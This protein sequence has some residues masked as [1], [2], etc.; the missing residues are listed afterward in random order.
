MSKK[1]WLNIRNEEEKTK[2]YIN[3]DIESDTWN[4]GFYEAWGINDTSVYPLVVKDALDGAEGEVEIHINSC[5]G[6]VFA[7][8]AISNMI[9]SYKGPTVAYVDGLAASAAS[10]IALACDKVIIPSNAYLMIHRVSGGLWGNADDFAKAIEAFEVL[11]EGIIN[12]Y[13]EKVKD[14]VSRETI[15]DYLKAETWFT[16]EQAAEVFNIEVGQAANIVNYASTKDKTVK[17]PKALENALKEAKNKAEEAL[18]QAE[19][20]KKQEEERVRDMEM[21]LALAL[22]F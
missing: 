19:A 14:G 12:G 13:M 18:K 3:G 4:D 17:L 20:K 11:E 1:K 22:A 8:V 6:D 10:V 5:G 16:G 15:T 7:G 21:A 2:I 9:K